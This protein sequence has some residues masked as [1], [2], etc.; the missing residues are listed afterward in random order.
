MKLF[1]ERRNILEKAVCLQGGF[2][3][4]VDLFFISFSYEEK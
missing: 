3:M 1:H 2:F 4:T